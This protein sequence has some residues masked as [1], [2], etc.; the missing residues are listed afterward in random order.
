[1]IGP[2]SKRSKSNR[3]HS[4]I[5]ERVVQPNRQMDRKVYKGK[6]QNLCAGRSQQGPQWTY[7]THSTQTD[8]QAR[9]ELWCRNKNT[10]R[11]GR[12]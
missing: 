10:K 12:R 4:A 3:L 8:K 1:M 7:D 9:N 6:A 2:K 5:A 11:I